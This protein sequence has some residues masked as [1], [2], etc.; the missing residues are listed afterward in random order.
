MKNKKTYTLDPKIITKTLK[1][2]D[3]DVVNEVYRLCYE[4]M[5]KEEERYSTIESKG[6]SLFGMIGLVIT[7]ILTVGGLLIEKVKNIP[8][9]FIECPLS[10]LVGF[11]T[12]TFTFALIASSLTLWALRIRSDYGWVSD[13]DVFQKN[14][15]A[16]GIISYKQYTA[17]H[18]WRIFIKNFEINMVKAKHL[19][20]AQIFFFLSLS[21]LV[22][23]IFIIS[24][25]ILKKGGF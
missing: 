24:L 9:Y 4:M 18:Y 13:Q 5:L 11:Y 12:L 8:V 10:W 1:T 7:I 15:I 21:V 23:I 20:I 19:R 6:W 22:P 2:A 3:E 16:D 17:V 14:K 25:Y